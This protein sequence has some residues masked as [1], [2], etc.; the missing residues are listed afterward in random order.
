MSAPSGSRPPTTGPS[1]A[2]TPSPSCTTRVIVEPR[3]SASPLRSYRPAPSRV[4]CTTRRCAGRSS[5]GVGTMRRRSLSPGE[6]G[7]SGGGGPNTT[8]APGTPAA[9]KPTASATPPGGPSRRSSCPSTSTSSRPARSRRWCATAA[10]RS[11]RAGATTIARR[12]ILR[13]APTSSAKPEDAHSRPSPERHHVHPLPGRDLE[14]L[15][16]L[17]RQQRVVPFD[18]QRRA[19]G[20]KAYLPFRPLHA[21]ELGGRALARRELA[22]RDAQP[23]AGAYEGHVRQPRLVVRAAVE[24]VDAI[25]VAEARPLEE[26]PDALRLR[27]H[28]AQEPLHA[29]RKERRVDIARR[30][31]LLDELLV[32]AAELVRLLVVE[33]GE[34]L[35]ARLPEEAP[36]VGEERRHE[37]GQDRLAEALAVHGQEEE[38]HVR[39]LLAWLLGAAAVLRVDDE[40]ADLGRPVEVVADGE[41]PVLEVAVHRRGVVLALGDVEEG[42]GRVARPVLRD[43]HRRAEDAARARLLQHEDVGARERVADLPP[44]AAAAL[45]DDARQRP[46]V[47][48]QVHRVELGR[49]RAERLQIGLLRV[50]EEQHRSAA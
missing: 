18:A 34:A 49:Q 1:S 48:G 45:V 15:L 33:A 39:E 30:E 24:G 29:G 46:L 17:R 4:R 32:L 13:R 2:S 41:D 42:A 21:D 38:A 25:H 22:R 50:A 6:A 12:S 14:E 20:A 19:D 31:E 35:A 27:R 23:A 9:C 44:E 11:C 26:V 28:L 40:P 37:L 3:C 16:R 8:R 43:D 36:A 47:V 10:S 7:S 5:T